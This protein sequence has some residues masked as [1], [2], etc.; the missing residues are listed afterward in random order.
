MKNL[1]TS[2]LSCVVWDYYFSCGYSL[3]AAATTWP[4]TYPVMFLGL[5][6]VE[7]GTPLSTRRGCPQ[8]EMETLENSKDGTLGWMGSEGFSCCRLQ[9]WAVGVVGKKKKKVGI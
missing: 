5:D 1:T 7:E 6:W 9:A 3:G 8:A 2:G 4:W